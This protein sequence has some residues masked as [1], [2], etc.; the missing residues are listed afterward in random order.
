MN[1]L[2]GFEAWRPGGNVIDV[3]RNR[4]FGR[5]GARR[6]S[7]SWNGPISAVLEPADMVNT[8]FRRGRFQGHGAGPATKCSTWNIG[9]CRERCSRSLLEMF[10]VEHQHLVREG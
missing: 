2:T 3:Y 8:G 5:D 6:R 10:L 1:H 9:D 7:R 4:E